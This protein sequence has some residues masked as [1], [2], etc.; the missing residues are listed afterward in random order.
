MLI[1]FFLQYERGRNNYFEIFG[2]RIP[3]KIRN[4]QKP[5]N[6]F[7]S[8]SSEQISKQVTVKNYFA[9]SVDDLELQIL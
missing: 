7:S 9:L 4:I 6:I 1:A 5:Q 3:K 8:F 2:I